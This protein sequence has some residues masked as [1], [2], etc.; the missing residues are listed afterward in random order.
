[1]DLKFTKLLD[2]FFP[3]GKFWEMQSNVLKITKGVS[4]EFN[5]I[6]IQA[7]TFYEDFNIIKSF[8]LADKHAEDYLIL[9]NLYT[10]RE[11][12]RI[13]VKYLNQGGKLKEIVIDFAAFINTPIQFGIGKTPFIIGRNTTG[14]MLG[15][16]SAV[17]QKMVLYIEFLD[18]NDVIN[19]KKVKDLVSYLK[20]PYLQVIYNTT[21][22]IQNIPFVV[23][24]NN[25]GNPLGQ[26]LV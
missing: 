10:K 25:T 4:D 1:M 17:S 16:P 2:N 12:Q 7:K 3:K 23:G 8:V 11:L 26:I 20:P 14:N 6:Y 9:K 15:D 24:R 22:D 21:N 19:I 18:I 5:R 13:I